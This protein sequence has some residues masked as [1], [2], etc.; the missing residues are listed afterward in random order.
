MFRDLHRGRRSWG[1]GSKQR[2][3]EE[4]WRWWRGY[5]W[6]LR[7]ISFYLRLNEAM[8]GLEQRRDRI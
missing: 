5:L 2:V 7:T 6:H 1:E 3:K 4:N 8:G